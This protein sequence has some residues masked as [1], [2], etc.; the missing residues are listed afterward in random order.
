MS[1]KPMPIA[2]YTATG[3]SNSPLWGVRLQTQVLLRWMAVIGQLI[4]VILVD[5]ILD[6]PVPLG[7][8][9]AA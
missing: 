3:L 1:L 6:Y 4:A 8:C 7:L 2:G 5:T 9:F